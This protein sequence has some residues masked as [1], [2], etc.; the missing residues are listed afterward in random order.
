MT[1]NITHKSILYFVFKYIDIKK[2]LQISLFLL[3]TLSIA[4]NGF[5]ETNTQVMKG[6]VSKVDFGNQSGYITV[7]DS[8]KEMVFFGNGSMKISGEFKSIPSVDYKVIVYYRETK[9]KDT[10]YIITKLINLTKSP[11]Y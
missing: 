1:N 7:K 5:A 6:V 4:T 10:P 8:K 9:S 11:Y 2:I 3:I